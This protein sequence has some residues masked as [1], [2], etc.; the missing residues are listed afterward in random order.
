M[1][2]YDKEDLVLTERYKNALHELMLAEL[3]MMREHEPEDA[4]CWTWGFCKVG[5]IAKVN[6]LGFCFGGDDDK[7]EGMTETTKVIEL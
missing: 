1:A 4:E 7:P 6:G 3:E 5:D 2:N